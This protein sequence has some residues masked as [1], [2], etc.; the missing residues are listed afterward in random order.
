[1]WKELRMAVNYSCDRCGETLERVVFKMRTTQKP[2]KKERVPGVAV[3]YTPQTVLLGNLSGD[4][5]EGC[6][7]SLGVWWEK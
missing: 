6:I 4:L 1:V 3:P 2:E 7:T 5:C